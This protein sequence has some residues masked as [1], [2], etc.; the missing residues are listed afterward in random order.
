MSRKPKS[1]ISVF[2]GELYEKMITGL[3]VTAKIIENTYPDLDNKQVSYILVLL[4]KQ[5]GVQVAKDGKRIRLFY[6]T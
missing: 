6:S 1:N 3:Q 2:A 4:K 5:K